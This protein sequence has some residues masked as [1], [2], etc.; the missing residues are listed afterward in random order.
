MANLNFGSFGFTRFAT[1][2]I[3]PLSLNV[4]EAMRVWIPRPRVKTR[5]AS[6][7]GISKPVK[8][9]RPLVPLSS[10]SFSTRVIALVRIKI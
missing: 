10:R 7:R 1:T 4:M 8:N 5:S 3:F 2:C 9:S 6:A